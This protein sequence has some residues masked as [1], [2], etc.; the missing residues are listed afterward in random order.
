MI[1]SNPHTIHDFSFS[2]CLNMLENTFQTYSGSLKSRKIRAF[3]F[4]GTHHDRHQTAIAHDATISRHQSR[5][6]RQA[7]VLPH[8]RFLR[9]VF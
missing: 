4:T 1:V 9:I 6:R 2:G 3:S 5:T 7:G 8:G